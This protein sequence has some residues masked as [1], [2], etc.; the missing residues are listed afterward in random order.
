MCGKGNSN[1]ICK[2]NGLL[3]KVPNKSP[4]E[5]KKRRFLQSSRCWNKKHLGP[6]FYNITAQAVVGQIELHATLLSWCYYYTLKIRS[7][8]L[9][10]LDQ[11]RHIQHCIQVVLYINNIIVVIFLIH[12]YYKPIIWPSRLHGRVCCQ[13]WIF[14]FKK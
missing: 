1:V 12:L 14:K 6:F 9:F 8:D 5:N 2:K 11:I 10:Y 7:I 13:K 3:C 4:E